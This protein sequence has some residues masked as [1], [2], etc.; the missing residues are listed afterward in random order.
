MNASPLVRGSPGASIPTHQVKDGDQDG[1][2][3]LLRPEK[4]S[5]PVRPHRVDE[6]WA[7]GAKWVG[8]F[9]L[10]RS[11]QRPAEAIV[12]SR[13]FSS[14]KKYRSKTGCRQG[15]CSFGH[16]DKLVVCR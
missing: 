16:G 6:G 14:R 2:L 1:H 4:L 11:V 5:P 3:L 9:P 12:A 13:Q 7:D 10:S 15:F 8:S